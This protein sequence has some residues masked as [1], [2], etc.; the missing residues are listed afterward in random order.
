[1]GFH[2][3]AFEGAI[4]I[5]SAAMEEAELEIHAKSGEKVGDFFAA[6]YKRLRA[7]ANEEDEAPEEIEDEEKDDEEN[8]ENTDEGE[9][10]EDEDEDGEESEETES[11]K[12]SGTFEVFKDAAGDYRFNLKAANNQIIAVSQG[13]KSRESCLKGIASVQRSSEKAVIKEIE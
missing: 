3:E 6:V 5:V 2:E 7:I 13:Y 12:R 10:D 9:D 4:E 1:M 11:E 8:E